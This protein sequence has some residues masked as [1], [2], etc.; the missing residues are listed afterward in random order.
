[1]AMIQIAM[2]HRPFLTGMFP[3]VGFFLIPIHLE[4]TREIPE[5][6]PE[7]PQIART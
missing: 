7:S 2:A 6:F 4:M 5:P 3:P 1:M